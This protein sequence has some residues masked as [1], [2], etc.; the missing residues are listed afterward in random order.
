MYKIP[1]LLAPAG[2]MEQLK[3]AVEN[4]ADAVYMGG[5]LFNARIN[6]GNFNDDEVIAAADY[7]HARGVKLYI[8]MNTL[9]RDQ[10][11]RAAL[12]YAAFLFEEGIDALIVQDLGFAGLLQKNIPEL[13]I[14][15]STQGTIY[16]AEG[17]RMA[18]K[19][20]FS[21]VVM[22]REMTLDE[23]REINR[24]NLLET[25]VFVHGALCICYSGQCQMSREIGGR[26]GNRGECAQPCRLPYSFCIEDHGSMKEITDSYYALSPKDLCMLDHLGAISEAEVASLKIEGRMKSPEYV[27]IVTGIYRRYL[28]IYAKSGQYHVDP[29]DL[30]DIAQIFNRGGFTQGY[31][32]ENPGKSFMSGDLSKHQ[33]IY[34]G[35]V[36]K[37]SNTARSG[38]RKRGL[39]TIH[40][41]EELSM[42]DGIEI[43][44][45]ELSGNIVTYMM[46]DG[47]K[48]S[49]APK[50][51]TV[52]AGYFDGRIEP[53]DR[54]YKITD[55]SLMLKAK[56]TYEGKSGSD[57]KS[58]RK[59]GVRF[60]LYASIGEAV[61]LKATDEDGNS[62]IKVL[63]I[64]PEK[65]RTKALDRE[66]VEAQ[67]GKT[68]GTPFRMTE[69]IADIEDGIS[70]PL[71]N[72]NEL[73]RAALAD[74]LAC[75]ISAS[76]KVMPIGHKDLEVNLRELYFPASGNT[77]MKITKENDK[78]KEND[79]EQQKTFLYLFQVKKEER[80]DF[81]IS[82]LYIPYE[83]MLAGFYSDYGMAVPVIPNI[84]K[85]YHDKMIRQNFDKIVEYS[86]RI[87]I[88]IGN[89]SW[90]EPFAKAG[91]NIIG[92]YGLNLY[93]SADFLAAKE[94]GISEAV[95]SHDAKP[96]DII[97]MD[98]HGVIPE[99]TIGGKIPV[100]TSEHCLIGDLKHSDFN[101]EQKY[102][103]KDR[104]GEFFPV[105][106]SRTDCR[107][108]VLSHKDIKPP[109]SKDELKKAG[110]KHL[111]I[112]R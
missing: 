79:S 88:A 69:C 109:L 46:T 57:E 71:A 64:S 94:L 73:R 100:M 77:E 63:G 52:T 54:V 78:N 95:I 18:K 31:L 13:N 10:E 12:K 39:A 1:E 61:S 105:L 38:D 86:Y 48:S 68:G 2:G 110:I 50:G 23:I 92:D 81:S 106:I 103:L 42:G 15:L 59:I 93:N 104:R 49:F 112:Y 5:K 56:A 9:I 91:V 99:L 19:L 4:G 47:K 27:A 40:L 97:K 14:H 6:A 72:I 96:E 11:L 32:Y 20:G 67:L 25:E 87:G 101:E 45:R 55:K 41:E 24:L 53:G 62:V 58:L 44:N 76:K 75:R 36:L 65:A 74:L 30:K 37:G 43:R 7:A 98:F 51:K 70:V 108:T 28:D 102:Y 107:S 84:T 17:V 8:T 22:A 21:R 3:A 82:R 29:A 83:A 85:G 35:K 89:L 26:S 34:I 16:N 90:I 33:G 66:I 80:I 60:N 111:R